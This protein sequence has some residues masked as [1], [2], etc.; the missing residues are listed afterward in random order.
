[1]SGIIS[2]K[3]RNYLRDLAK[4]QVEIANSDEMLEKEKLWYA[5]NDCETFEPV[6]T[7]EKWTFNREFEHLWKPKCESETARNLE[8]Y[9]HSNAVQYEYIHDDTVVPRDYAVGIH[10]W[11]KPF[12]VDVKKERSIGETYAFKIDYE[13]KDLESDF[14]KLKKSPVG[15]NY[16]SAVNWKKTV[17]DI[18]GDIMPV[19]FSFTP[20]CSLA[21]NIY[22]LM[23]LETM[24]LSMYDYPELFHKMMT[25]LSDDYVE[26][27]KLAEDNGYIEP[28]NFNT[29][30]PQGS[31]GFSHELPKTKGG[32]YNLV[33]VWGYMDSQ[34]TSE[35]SPD[36]YNE[37]FF[38]YYKKISERFGLFNYGC[39]ESVSAIWE[40][41]VSN[42]ENLRKVSISPWCDEEYIGD[43]LCG[44]KIIYHRK[45]FPNYLAIDAEFDEKGFETHIRKTLEAAKGCYLEF[46]YRDV[47]SLQGDIFRGKK[48]YEIIKKSIEK[49][50]K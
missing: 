46:S 3:E 6:V 14:Q 40:K 21:Q 10:A 41:S 42:Y 4:K 7:L 49:Y 2:E 36:M 27:W 48:A 13:I 9:F 28:N 43:K 23:G 19:R 39:C 44:K 22:N 33:D 5:H 25:D 11:V 16:D 50:F 26:L 47:Y 35:I 20:C 18:I 45:P 31:Y 29:G 24:M 30:V 38:P 15:C 32:A 12:D 8:Y 37:F 1:M 34:E 17:E